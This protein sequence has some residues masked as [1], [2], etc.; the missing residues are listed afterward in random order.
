M[1]VEH[2]GPSPTCSTPCATAAAAA[3]GVVGDRDVTATLVGT[4]P[5]RVRVIVRYWH[6]PMT[7][8]ATTTAVVEALAAVLA[9]RSLAAAVS[10]PV[11]PP[12]LP[13]PPTV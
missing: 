13:P 4:D 10:S 6:R 7:S 9:D 3:D 11:P 1:R 5:E 8:Y 2:P 12:T